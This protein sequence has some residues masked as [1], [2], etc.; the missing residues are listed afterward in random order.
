M[1]DIE[2]LTDK[3]TNNPDI[4]TKDEI[5]CHF[6]GNTCVFDVKNIKMT[7]LYDYRIKELI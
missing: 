1:S 5:I 2:L 6:A 4:N 7:N 3:I